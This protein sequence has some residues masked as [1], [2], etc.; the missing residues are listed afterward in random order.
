MCGIWV[1]LDQANH[2]LSTLYESFLK[3]S[4]RG[5]DHSIFEV[6]NAE[7]TTSVVGFHRLAIVNSSAYGN[8]PFVIEDNERRV[9]FVCN[10]EIYNWKA[11]RH[12]YGL[13]CDN[14]CMVIPM[15][16]MQ[17]YHMDYTFEEFIAELKGEFAFVLLEFRKN[18]L[19]RVVTARDEIGVRPLYSSANLN[20]DL[21]FT[22]EVKGAPEGIPV[23]EFPPGTMSTY[24]VNDGTEE[25]HYFSSVYLTCDLAEKEDVHLRLIE[26]SVRNA[27]NRRLSASKPF[28]YLLSGGVDSSLV[29]ALGAN[30]A[31]IAGLDPIKTF[32]CSI[33]PGT[34]Q[35]GSG[36]P[37]T[38]DVGTD[39]LYAREVAAHIGSD[40][41]EVFFTP[42]EGINAIG[43]VIR[44]VESWDTTTVRAS[45][46]QYMVCKWIGE[47]TDCKVVMV[48][49][50][51]DE[52]CSSYLF[53]WYAPNGNALDLSARQ[54]VKNIHYYDVKRADRCISR[55][56]LEGRVPLLDPDFIRAY[57]QIPGSL[58]LPKTKGIEKWWLRAAFEGESLLPASVLWRK[59][60]A[61]SD[62]VSATKSWYQML[63]DFFE[64]KVS[65]EG[66][67]QA[68]HDFPYCPPT[69]KEAYVYRC[70][71]ESF[72]P[73]RDD[74][75]PGFWQPKW[76]AD[77]VVT[78]YVDPSARTLGL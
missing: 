62:G 60:E 66:L 39:L 12:K 78:T 56:G 18:V 29:A 30:A 65:D 42:Q 55:W 38:T 57:W 6:Y 36:E 35:L 72:F 61:F 3:L 28:A 64:D 43:D 51:P 37:F 23:K 8:Q 11:L 20:G 75:I 26:N 63:Q 32:C 25:V 47:N 76:N 15:M 4:H 58:R 50:G 40:H 17:C 45:V 70:M 46:G 7:N 13:D 14:D 52:V 2:T 5:P 74:I 9:V 59:K 49:E 19:E 53:N 33:K 71:F 73:G 1:L 41:T 21:F 77:G 54:Y 67:K 16:Y 44:T 68:T 24:Y 22:S 10:G 34:Y 69:T 27:V 31:R 48:G